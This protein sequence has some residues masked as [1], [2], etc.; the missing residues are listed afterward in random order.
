MSSL[1]QSVRRLFLEINQVSLFYL[2]VCL[3]IFG[4]CWKPGMYAK[5]A[6]ELASRWKNEFGDS[7]YIEIT[8]TGRP[9]EETFVRES[10]GIAL[11]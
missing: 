1:A 3:D 4:I 2:E 5:G 9:N 8:R 10:I 6:R 7:Y 11:N